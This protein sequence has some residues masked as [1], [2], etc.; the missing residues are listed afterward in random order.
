VI[1]L[2]GGED[3]E[4]LF[5]G[6]G[7]KEPKGFWLKRGG[8]VGGG[9]ERKLS[10]QGGGGFWGGGCPPQTFREGSACGGG[11]GRCSVSCCVERKWG[12]WGGG[13]GSVGRSDLK[14]VT[15]SGI[16][17]FFHD[18]MPEEGGGGGLFGGRGYYGGGGGI[19][20]SLTCLWVWWDSVIT[21]WGG[22]PIHHC[23]LV[24]A[25]KN[26]RTKGGGGV[27]QTNKAV[28]LSMGKKDYNGWQPV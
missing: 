13:G 7:G 16:K 21:L 24:Q 9:K 3:P 11:V 14:E 26:G 19:L 22:K 27:W 23:S 20:D 25:Q 15:Q 28:Q 1:V 2:W 5:E 8:G 4:V 10:L 18:G 12:R 17:R 6:G